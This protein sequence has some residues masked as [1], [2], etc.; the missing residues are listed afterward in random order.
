MKE[1]KS[2]QPTQSPSM[3]SPNKLR[4]DW[5]FKRLCLLII[6]MSFHHLEKDLDTIITRVLEGQGQIPKGEKF[7]QLRSLLK[8][9]V[10]RLLKCK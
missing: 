10:S 2:Q 1:I 8:G 7:H 3:S 5:E 9:T 6:L 4:H